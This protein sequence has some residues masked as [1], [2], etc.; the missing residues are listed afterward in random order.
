MNGT[1]T[2][3]ISSCVSTEAEVSTADSEE[4]EA[5][6][7]VTSEAETAGE[8]PDES[9]AGEE[10]PD[11]AETEELPSAEETAGDEDGDEER[12]VRKGTASCLSPPPPNTIVR[13]TAQSS[14]AAPARMLCRLRKRNPISNH[15]FLLTSCP[16]SGTIILPYHMPGRNKT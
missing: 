12:G 8:E 4:E 1:H 2:P 16:E 14:K 9:P 13:I 3:R 6:P 5:A 11:A 10:V 7:E 15:A